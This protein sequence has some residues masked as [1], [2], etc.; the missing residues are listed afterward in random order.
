MRRLDRIFTLY[1]FR[2][3]LRMVGNREPHVPVLMY[4][5]ISELASMPRHPYFEIRTSPSVFRVQMQFLR[6]ADFATLLPSEVFD[7]LVTPEA[8]SRRAVCLTFDDA[9]EDFLIAALPILQEFSFK[10]TV[11]V[12]TGMVGNSGPNGLKLLD[13]PQIRTLGLA[14]VNIG[15]HTVSHP[16][17]KTLSRSELKREIVESKKNL[18]DKLGLKIQDF[19]HPF[20]FPE[21]S[22]SYV[23]SYRELLLEGNY[24][25]GMTTVIGS[26][27]K[28]D[29]P[30]MIRRLP[31]NDFDDNKLLAAKLDSSYDWL[32][33]I[34]IL[35]K[36]IR[37]SA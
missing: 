35:S 2:P 27:R 23:D 28:G 30:L 37:R 11:Y 31:A 34:Q 15:S 10:S 19:S 7:W 4:H 1:F 32:H 18:E 12:P 13:W 24:R 22:S 26:V 5:S 6:D 25:T 21:Q 14:G 33:Q 8:A 17:M 16:D 9:Y 20:A 3:V 36:T 29:D